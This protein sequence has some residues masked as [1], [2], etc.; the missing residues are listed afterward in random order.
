MHVT[1]RILAVAALTGVACTTPGAAGAQSLPEFL[2]AVRQG[3]G[4]ITL[5]IEKGTGKLLTRPL[6]TGGLSL[7]G[8]LEIWHGHSGAFDVRIED[9]YGNGRLVT[10]ARPAQDV[11]FTYD[12][13][14]WAQLDVNVRWS[15]PR[16]TTLVV[17]VGL[18]RASG[19]RDPCEPVYAPGG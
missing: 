7:N 1:L 8:C 6:P 2:G 10:L 14:A 3:G 13:G 19:E 11:P 17:W 18:G 4:W 5:P 12:T 15:E 16:D 9:T